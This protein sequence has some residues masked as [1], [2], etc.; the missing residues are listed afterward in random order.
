MIRGDQGFSPLQDMVSGKKSWLAYAP[1]A[2]SGWSLGVVIPE[3]ELL[4]GIRD[5]SREVLLIGLL[6]GILLVIA[7]S[8]VAGTI[9]RPLRFL[10]LKT[11]EIAQ[12]NLDSELPEPRSRMRS[13]SWPFPSVKC[14]RP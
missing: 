7:I 11:R 1:L 13:G 6:G 8:L 10:A 2:S 9:T 4:A 14:V 12:G 5:L 3:E